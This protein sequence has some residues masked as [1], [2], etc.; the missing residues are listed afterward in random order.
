MTTSHVQDQTP[1]FAALKQI[2]F[3]PTILDG[4]MCDDGEFRMS[5]RSTARAIGCH[6]SVVPKMLAK[7]VP[8]QTSSAA[9]D[10]SDST[11]EIAPAGSAPQTASSTTGLAE[12]RLGTSAPTGSGSDKPVILA[13]RHSAGGGAAHTIN[14]ATVV[15][16]WGAMAKSQSPYAGQAFDLV[17]MCAAHS[18]EARFQEAF[19]VTDTRNTQD[20][21]IDWAVNFNPGKHEPLFGGKFAKEFARVTGAAIG[22]PYARVC[23]AELVYDRL[24][25]RIYDTL[26]ELNPQKPDGWRE[27]TYSQ[28]MTEDMKE[29]IRKLLLVVT[30]ELANAP[31]KGEEPKA[32]RTVLKRLDLLPPREKKRGRQPLPPKDDGQMELPATA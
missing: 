7:G 19:G 32:Y 31:G 21:L 13:L 27:Y 29:E 30:H 15:Q 22:H 10:L 28:L 8:A 16:L 2:A 26:K 17:M 20:R 5:M 6:H 18:L 1:Q 4:Y 12:S 23:L 25:K 11:P 9:T 24:P 3:G 14:I